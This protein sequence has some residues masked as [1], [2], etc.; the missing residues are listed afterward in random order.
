MDFKRTRIK[1]LGF[2]KALSIA[3]R[4]GRVTR[5][6]PFEEP[7]V[8]PDFRGKIEISEDKCIGCGACVNACPP[9][10]L[11]KISYGKGLYAIKYFIGRCIYCWRC[12]DV[13]PVNAIT[14]SREFELATNDLGDL[15]ELVVHDMVKC[16]ICGE[17]FISTGQRNYVLAR[18]PL[19]EK[20]VNID[21]NCRKDMFLQNI[22]K[23]FGG[24]H[25]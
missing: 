5:K 9:N 10:A 21:P 25:D 4:V 20:Y 19:T 8:T 23:R 18:S 1:R 7:L 14:G 16:S 13:C 11:E 3:G 24:G 22:L 6:Y 2:V 17:Y 15:Y 12:I